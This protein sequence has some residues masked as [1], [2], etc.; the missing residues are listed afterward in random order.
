MRIMNKRTQ[1]SARVLEK[2][3]SAHT[4]LIATISL[5]TTG[6][7]LPGHLTAYAYTLQDGIPWLGAYGK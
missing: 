3:Q 1:P 6:F 4:V 7:T 2:D 5:R